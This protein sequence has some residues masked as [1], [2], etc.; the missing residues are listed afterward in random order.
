MVQFS[1]MK[2]REGS[3]LSYGLRA[4]GNHAES[5]EKDD[6]IMPVISRMEEEMGEWDYIQTIP[7]APRIQSHT[8]GARSTWKLYNCMNHYTSLRRF[9]YKL[10]IFNLSFVICKRSAFTKIE[11]I[12]KMAGVEW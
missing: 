4:W 8:L 3:F 11:V 2:M 1:L 7:A 5:L 12:R 6:Q 10:N 9:F